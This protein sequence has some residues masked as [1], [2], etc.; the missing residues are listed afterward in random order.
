MKIRPFRPRF[1]RSLLI[2]V[3][4]FVLLAYWQVRNWLYPQSPPIEPQPLDSPFSRVSFATE[5]GLTITAW[6]ASATGTAGGA[7]LLLHGHRGNRDQLLVHAEYLAAAGYGALL[8]DFRNHG[9]SGGTFTSMGYHEIKDA[10][11][12]YRYLERQPDVKRIALWGHSMGGAV[13]CQLMSEVDA[14]GLFVDAT[15]ADFPAVVRKGVIGRGLPASPIAEVMIAIYRFLS[16]S[17]W[18]AIRPIDQ[19]AAIDKPVLLFHGSDDPLIPLGEAERI[20]SANPHVRLSIFERGAHSDLYEVDPGRY[21]KEALAYLRK[22][23]EAP[24]IE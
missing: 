19:L 17:D 21:R 6:Y 11:A 23:F 16:G 8:I 14:A 2:A 24:F 7:V 3:G 5:D 13:A 22:A 12:A 15:F 18:S 20:A 9:E 1:V 4:I 10:R